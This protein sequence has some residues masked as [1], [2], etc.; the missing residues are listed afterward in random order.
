MFFKEFVLVVSRICRVDDLVEVFPGFLSLFVW[1]R[2]GPVVSEVV[3]GAVRGIDH[4]GG[5]E[6]LFFRKVC[7][8]GPHVQRVSVVIVQL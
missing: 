1:V 7:R 4:E 8:Q 2:I 3:S 5:F 6:Q